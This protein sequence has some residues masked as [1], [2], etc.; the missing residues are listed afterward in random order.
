[1]IRGAPAIVRGKRSPSP[2]AV[3]RRGRNVARIQK[4]EIRPIDKG[5]ANFQFDL[6]LYDRSRVLLVNMI[7]QELSD[8][9]GQDSETCLAVHPGGQFAGW[10]RIHVPQ[11]LAI[12]QE[13][14]LV[15]KQGRWAV[16]G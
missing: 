4:I 5:P 1:M 14:A 13:L 8:E 2:A 3:A 10:R 16:I 9:T 6:T 15:R 11:R 12:G 7:P